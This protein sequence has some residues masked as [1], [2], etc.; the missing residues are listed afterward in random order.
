[1]RDLWVVASYTI[2]DMLT[3]KSFL[4]SN[5]IILIIIVVGFNIP[6]IMSN[7]NSNGSTTNVTKE[8]IVDAE[9][10]YEGTLTSLNSLDLGYE[11][12]IENTVD[13]TY[14]TAVIENNLEIVSRPE[15]DIKQ[16]GKDK[17]FIFVVNVCVKPEATVKDYKGIEVKKV[18]T[19]V[20][21]KDVDAELEKIREKNARIVTVED[22][23]L[24][25]GD[26]SII[27]FEGF[28]DG[29]AFEGGKAENFELTVGSGQF[30]PGFED[31]MIGMKVNE[32]RDINVKFPEEY[33]V[34][35]LAGKDAT[36]KVKLHE[37]K[38]KVLPEIDDE[39]AK[40]VSEFDNLE[41][42]KKDLNKKIKADK[43]NHA[44]IDME[45][46]AIDKFIEKVEVTIPEEMIDSE[47]DK[48][49]EEMNANLSYQGLNI[50][51]YLQY[52]G[53]TLDE[54][55][56]QM[57]DQAQR[58][59]KLDLGLEYVAKEE[60]VEVEEKDIDE[61]IKEL[62]AQYGNKDDE[63]LLKNENARNYMRQQ[64]VYEKTMKVITDN[65][66]TK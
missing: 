55:K 34:K 27:D 44:K 16:I 13:D 51:Q 66:V 39:F 59:I 50:D 24:K 3:K 20:T 8:L 12:I 56:K 53:T 54:Y 10:I 49:I 17:D 2:K 21:K 26:I 1:M 6:N 46:E 48:M 38:E 52:M 4:I 58:R 7:F 47:V 36:F 45:Q 18:S 22:R 30:I 40:D 61:K 35:D 23:E 31:Q 5:L 60:K 28:T 57:R 37:I 63:S 32:E 15:L 29:K 9:N 19:R 33:H 11:F 14:R 62:A 42:Y 41:D 64:L 65:I 25:N 43:E